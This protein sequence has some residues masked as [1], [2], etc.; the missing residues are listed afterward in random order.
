L[1]EAA[2]KS[3]AKVRRAAVG[4]VP[5][6]AEIHIRSWQAA[7]RGVLPDSLLDGLSAVEREQSWHALLSGGDDRWLTLVGEDPGGGLT[8][9]CAVAT[10][11]R[12]KGPD[13]AAAEIGALYVDPGHWREGVGSAMLSAALSTLNQKGWRD[14]VLWVLPE[15]RP[16]LAFYER[17]GF[18][19]EPGV[20]KREERSG[21]GV[22]RLRVGLDEPIRLAPYD[23]SWPARFAAERVALDEAIGSWATGGIHHVGSTAVPGL[24]AKPIVDILVGVDS[25]EASR[26]CFDPLAKLDYLYAPYRADE[27]HW[28]CKPH[29]SR[30]THHLHLVPT[31]SKRF[32]DELAFRDRLRASPGTA[33]EYATLKRDLAERFADD[34]EAYTDAKADFIRRALRSR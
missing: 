15:N 33:E 11:S 26:A 27:M 5:G 17:F 31:D 23:P 3:E 19:V 24:A 28:F 4:D 1:T 30:R 29:P 21:R 6:I 18:V 34:R 7:Y 12:D 32:R 9:F 14:V 2:G 13:G 10:P 16:A 22:I 20:E 25:L 8:G